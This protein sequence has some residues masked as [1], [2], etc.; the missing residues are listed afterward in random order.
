MF[1]LTKYALIAAL[2]GALALAGLLVWEKSKNA[3]LAAD[4]ERLTA[5]LAT[6]SARITNIKEDMEDDAT[7]TDPS[8]F[9][10]PDSW[11]RETGTSD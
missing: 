4:V 10:V 6:C 5:S 11:M 7:V 3:L 8:L 9:D 1:G 2:T